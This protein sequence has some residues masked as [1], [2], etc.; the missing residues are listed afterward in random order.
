ME[1]RERQPAQRSAASSSLRGECAA[2]PDDGESIGSSLAGFH[3]PDE[4]QLLIDPEHGRIVDANEAAARFYGWPRATLRTFRIDRLNVL[5]WPE[6]VAR[7]R[8]VLQRSTGRFVFLHR[9]ADHQIRLVEVVTAPVQVG[10]R[11]FLRS[12]VHDLGEVLARLPDF[13]AIARRYQALIEQ[14]PAVVYAEEVA[15]PH[16]KVYVSPAA[17]RLL[18]WSPEQLQVDRATWYERF[19]LPEDRVWVLHQEEQTDRSGEPFRV[20]YRFRTGDG[21]VVWL[22][23]EAILVTDEGG[24]PW[25]WH[26]ILTDVTQQKRIEARLQRE[27]AFHNVLLGIASN[28]VAV[29]SEG[30]ETALS[31]I[32]AD[33]G[34]FLAV[35]ALVLFCFQNESVTLLARWQASGQSLSA[36]WPDDRTVAELTWLRQ[37]L[38]QRQLVLLTRLEQ[39]PEEAKAER[40]V[41]QHL[42]VRSL[43]AVPLSTS[44]QLLGCLVAAQQR[45][46]RLWSEEEIDLLT[47]VGQ[48]IMAAVLQRRAEQ[49]EA[50]HHA[51]LRA[52]VLASP[53]A[54][55]VLDGEGIVRF[56]S[57]ASGRVLGIEAG[58]AVGHRLT[59]FI[60]DPERLQRWLAEELVP[61]RTTRIELSLKDRPSRIVEISGVDLVDDPHIGGVVLSIRDVTER[62]RAQQLLRERAT[63]DPLTG[64]ANRFGFLE[65]L[66]AFRSSAEDGVLGVLCC[67]LERFS[68]LNDAISWEAG[69][70]AL[71]SV[72]DRLR[73]VPEALIAARLEADR[74]AVLLRADDRQHLVRLATALLEHSSDWYDVGGEEVYLS[75]RGGLAFVEPD[76]SPVQALRR[77]EIAFQASKRQQ[78]ERL[79]VFDAELYQ[80]SVDRQALERDLRRALEQGDL[81]LHYQ[82]VVDLATGRIVSVEALVRWYH[83]TRGAVSPAVFVPLAEVTGLISHLTQWVLLQACRQLRSWLRLGLAPDLTVSVNLSPTD[84]LHIDVPQLAEDIL[85][86]IGLPPERLTLEMTES[87]MLDPAVSR[88]RLERLRA[89]GIAVVID[90]FGAGYSSLGYLKRLPVHGIKL[91][92]QLIADIHENATSEAVVRSVLELARSL[93][94]SVTAEGIENERQ[95]VLLRSLGCDYGQ[96]FA[97]ARPRPPEAIVELLR[98]QQHR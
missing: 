58:A 28:L 44:G 97:I 29:T 43:V 78:R 15:P 52:T 74:F 86:V 21:R 7:M 24:R 57:P 35:D 49:V 42:G 53:D 64:L 1:G 69:D 56:A 33:V 19:V 47:L 87:A 66:E 55:L 6:I 46:Q 36:Q 75:M 61:D 63:R 38:E 85:H 11:T 70:A 94:L 67:D 40:T 48:L 2:R 22:R 34:Q 8:E 93:R 32:L 17:E 95:L 92:R 14:L 62:H 90:D 20:E 88:E 3:G 31:T 76:D 79:A 13:E 27:L 39:L 60:A 51:W 50:Q 98:E 59:E 30:L 5:P 18:G 54:L 45:E 4:P 72:A 83:P 81:H 84:F 12:T 77:A 16:R 9:F 89:L 10:G 71:R 82:P 65:A 26:G 73:G 91:D 96:G 25:I 68:A 80:A 37:R 41:F 23:D